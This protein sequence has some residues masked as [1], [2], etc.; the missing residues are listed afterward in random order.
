MVVIIIIIILIII[1]FSR[2]GR[3]TSLDEVAYRLSE[4]S[5]DIRALRKQVDKLSNQPIISSAPEAVKPVAPAIKPIEEVKAV[6]ITPQKEEIRQPQ[7]VPEKPV[8][9]FEAPSSKPAQEPIYET[10][11]ASWFETWLKNNPDMEKFIGENLIN[12]I[13]IAVLVLGIAFFVKYAI[14]KDWINEVGRIMSCL[15]KYID[16]SRPSYAEELSFF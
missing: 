14:D 10:P 7:V 5:D 4:L 6:V 11:K 9:V 13:G 8:P 1:A 16:W 3:R 15:R 2:S 12:K